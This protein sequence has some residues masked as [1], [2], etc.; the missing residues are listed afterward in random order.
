MIDYI[1]I[2]APVERVLLSACMINDVV[3][4]QRCWMQQQLNRG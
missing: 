2:K 3:G 1:T 4:E